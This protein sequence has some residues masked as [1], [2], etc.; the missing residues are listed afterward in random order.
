MRYVLVLLIT[1]LAAAPIQA[2]DA[3]DTPVAFG[4]VI[5]GTFNNRTPR[6]IYY[7]DGLRCEAISVRLRATSGNLDPIL[8]ILDNTGTAIATRDDTAGSLEAHIDLL[9]L[10][11]AGR[12]YIV[13]GRFGYGLG[14]TAGNYE[15]V[16]ERIGNGSL[17]GCALRYGD[18]A[19][20][21]INNDE[22]EVFYTFQAQAGDIV[23]VSMR[24]SSGN[25]DA[26]VLVTDSA[27]FILADS[28]DIL[29]SLD[30]EVEGLFIPADGTYFII[31]T[32]YG[33]QVGSTGQV[34]TSS[35]NYILT[36]QEAANSGLGNSAQGAIPIRMGDR[37]E[38][39]ISADA[40]VRYYRFEARQDDIINIRMSRI[41]GNLDSYIALT[42]AGLQELVANDDFGGSQNSFIEDYRIPAN[43]TY[44][45]LA[46]RFEGESGRSTGRYR[47]DLEY[48]GNAFGAVP[49]SIQ[50]LIYNVSVTGSI[51]DVTPEVLYAFYG[52][53]GDTVTVSMARGDGNLDP[54]LS[55]LD[56]DQRTVISND[57][58]GGQQNARIER[59]TLPSA[60]V[61]YIRAAR[62]SG[63][64]APATSGSYILVLA[65][66]QDG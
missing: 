35:G 34:G 3:D 51:D 15:L 4:Q 6:A 63:P 39:V 7:F 2:Q 31:A 62:F 10:P 5:S 61:Y 9:R 44:Y 12:Y 30:A 22:P 32:R 42:N 52:E 43:G 59:Y 38:G 17:S 45:I 56:A 40:V 49:E 33:Q 8:T 37:V 54:F 58:G 57:D 23:N 27:G 18:T 24:A 48:Q 21:R 19:F 26:Y 16:I 1:L 53:E 29:G 41:N 47:L 50:R 66:R 55:I 11:T 25:L 14:S 20:Y 60:G 64:G 13:A 36:L 65:L 28:D 46:T